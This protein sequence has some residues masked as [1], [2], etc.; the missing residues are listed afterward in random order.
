MAYEALNQIAALQPPQPDHRDQTTTAVHTRHGRGLARH[1]SSLRVDPRYERISSKSLR[2]LATS[3]RRIDG[4]PGRVSRQGRTEAL[5]QPSTVF[6]RPGHQYAGL[7]DGHDESA[8][9][10]IFRESNGCANPS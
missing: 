5:L 6:E 7:V 9:E 8:L 3:A 4:G 2:L 1:L 10:E